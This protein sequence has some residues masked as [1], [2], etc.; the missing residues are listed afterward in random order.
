SAPPAPKR[1]FPAGVPS[2]FRERWGSGL[3]RPDPGSFP[4]L[5]GSGCAATNKKWP[6]CN[7]AT[8]EKHNNARRV[9]GGSKEHI[10]MPEATKA[11]EPVPFSP[12][13]RSISDKINTKK[14]NWTPHKDSNQP[15]TLFGL[16]VETG[17]Y[18]DT[19][20]ADEP[21]PTMRLLTDQKVEWS[22]I[23]FHGWLRSAIQQQRP[24]VGDFVAV[25]Y[26]AVK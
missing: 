1:F 2:C 4:F 11:K 5:P 24:L 12:D 6:G 22:I 23:G 25:A 16:C 10:P 19:K 14:E 9:R 26:Q 13:E 20:Y 8:T 21:R 3:L 17:E 7:Q 15:Q 18:H